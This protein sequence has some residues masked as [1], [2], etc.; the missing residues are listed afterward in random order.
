MED[1]SLGDLA[2]LTKS[3][4]V[5]NVNTIQLGWLC[6]THGFELPGQPRESMIILP[7]AAR[8]Y[9][10]YQNILIAESTHSDRTRLE[11]RDLLKV[12]FK[13]YDPVRRLLVR[14]LVWACVAPT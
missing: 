3:T 11:P 14:V 5:I 9:V 1:S 4:T 8:T 12:N 2:E 6:F 7:Q 10:V 13:G